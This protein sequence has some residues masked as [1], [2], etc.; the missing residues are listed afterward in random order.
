MNML[1][2]KLVKVLDGDTIKVNATFSV[3][4]VMVDTPEKV[5]IEKEAGLASKAFLE[6]LL[7]G[8]QLKLDVM[9]TDMYDRF[10]SVLFLEDEKTGELFNANGEL[11][12]NKKAEFYIPGHHADGKLEI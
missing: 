4:L 10:L 1:D 11:I 9:K 3:R 8:K 6:K 12:K 5:G 2:C 7:E